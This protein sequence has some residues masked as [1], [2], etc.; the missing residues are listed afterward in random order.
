[1]QMLQV[2]DVGSVCALQCPP[3]VRYIWSQ[4]IAKNGSIRSLLVGRFRSFKGVVLTH[5]NMTADTE[6][7]RDFNANLNSGQ[8]VPGLG[9]Y[10][11]H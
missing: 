5:H 2:C 11:R 4:S 1:M 10:L 6:Q 7:V 3:M 8:S 9:C